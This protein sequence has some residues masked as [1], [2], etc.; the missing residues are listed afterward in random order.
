MI[1]SG[2]SEE[3]LRNRLLN[4]ER[5]SFFMIIQELFPEFQDLSGSDLVR[6]L[7]DEFPIKE[8]KGRWGFPA[9]TQ[10]LIKGKFELAGFDFDMT[11]GWT[12]TFYTKAEHKAVELTFKEIGENCNYTLAEAK[13]V[14]HKHIHESTPGLIPA[15]A[16]ASGLVGDKLSEEENYRRLQILFRKFSYLMEMFDREW[17][18]NQNP[19]NEPYHQLFATMPDKGIIVERVRGGTRLILSC[20]AAD[21][22]PRIFTNSYRDRIQYFLNQMGYSAL[23]SPDSAFCG[24][25][26]ILQGVRVNK[27]KEEFWK[28]ATID[29]EDPS[30]IV[31]FEDN[32]TAARWAL[33]LGKVG[34]V[35]VRNEI[36]LDQDFSE[37]KAEFPRRV[38][39][40]NDWEE[41]AKPEVA[42][43][44]L[45]LQDGSSSQL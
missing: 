1:G 24:D 29:V 35:F 27:G 26:F 12:K 4:G 45:N 42:G 7:N 38:F 11:L 43:H 13:I 9:L 36:Q 18:E 14:Y 40:V 33:E 21:L 30:K 31:I 5:H 10:F 23:I 41:F 20:L 8:R 37:L 32:P 17:Q 28:I 6:T 34:F 22:E 3:V 19:N 44:L 25:D 15:H 39:V 2:L 16:R